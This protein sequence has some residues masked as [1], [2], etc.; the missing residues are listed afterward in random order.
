MMAT[1]SWSSDE[2]ILIVII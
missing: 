2:N 1:Y